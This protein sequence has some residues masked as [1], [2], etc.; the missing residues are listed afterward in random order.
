[1]SKF[2][3]FCIFLLNYIFFFNLNAC[4]DKACI[5]SQILQ[6]NPHVI[7]Q[8]ENN[9]CY[10]DPESLVLEKGHLYLND[11]F[12]FLSIPSLFIDDGG[13]YIKIKKCKKS[14]DGDEDLPTW[15]Y[16]FCPICHR[17][18]WLPTHICP[19]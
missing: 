11:G 17:Y 9:K 3:V 5:F 15:G 6:E 10:L 1:M 2:F 18:V 8:I 16:G 4:E 19:D 13:C 7:I 12:N 14:Y